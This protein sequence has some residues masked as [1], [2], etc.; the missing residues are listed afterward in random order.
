MLTPDQA[1]NL[2]QE[3]FARVMAEVHRKGGISQPQQFGA[4]FV[5]IFNSVLMEFYR[6]YARKQLMDESTDTPDKALDLDGMLVTKQSAEQV[7]RILDAMPKRDRDLLRAIFLEER[8]KEA[9]CREMGVDPEYLRVLVR[10]TKLAFNETYSTQVRLWSEVDEPV[11]TKTPPGGT[12]YSIAES[13]CSKKTLDEIVRPLL[14]DMQFEYN[15]ALLA[16]HKWGATWVRVRGAWSFFTAL[17]INRIVGI[18][19]RI[20]LRF[21]S[22]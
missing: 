3:T 21:S 13:I 15:E 9:I 7:R 1:E 12:L 11:S 10:R 4:L 16:G 5:S 17:G 18:F 8:E 6:P 14:A 2:R 19:V 20:F 22:R